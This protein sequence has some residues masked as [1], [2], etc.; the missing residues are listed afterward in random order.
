V[1]D[2]E[3]NKKIKKFQET[4][5]VDM[6]LQEGSKIESRATSISVKMKID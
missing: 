5:Q 4:W 6:A 1:R 3:E 2:K